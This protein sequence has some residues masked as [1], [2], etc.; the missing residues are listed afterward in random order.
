MNDID[1]TDVWGTSDT[2]AD[3]PPTESARALPQPREEEQPSSYGA[4][5]DYPP[6]ATEQAPMSVE[7]PQQPSGWRPTPGPDATQAD[8]FAARTA[9]SDFEGRHE[10]I[11]CPEC[12]AQQSVNLNRRD[13]EDFCSRCDYPLFW[14][15]SRYERDRNE[16]A[17][18]T[19]RRLPGTGG[20][21][22]L[23][24]SACPHCAELNLVSAETC[25]RCGSPMRVIAPPPPP[26]PAP[27]LPPPPPEPEVPRDIAWW[28]IWLAVGSLAV[29]GVLLT[30]FLTG[31]IHT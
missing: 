9:A 22:K 7:V 11:T 17:A 5:M 15:P 31:V 21:T 6:Y 23:A 19:L 10:R 3:R 14:T 16:A 18:D 4:L 26:A 1:R 2:Y 30:L 27:Y 12:G 29:V 25:A 8:L 28:A 24:H 20:S 13:A